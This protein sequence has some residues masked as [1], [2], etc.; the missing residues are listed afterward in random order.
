MAGPGRECKFEQYRAPSKDWEPS[1]SITLF[2]T[3]DSACIKP[4][5]V[6]LP[7]ASYPSGSG[8]QMTAIL[9][10]HGLHLDADFHSLFNKEATRLREAVDDAGKDLILIAPYLGNDN[11]YDEGE[12]AQAGGSERYLNQVLKGLAAWWKQT[13]G[14]GDDDD[15]DGTNF[16]IETLIIGCHSRG[17]AAMRKI[18]EGL[19]RYRKKLVQCW[20]FDCTY[21]TG[22]TWSD[23]ARGM[24]DVDLYFYFGKGTQGSD[25]DPLGF[26]RLAYGSPKSPLLDGGGLQHV[27]LAPALPGVDRDSI[28]FQSTAQIQRKPNG[29]SPYEDT[30]KQADP[31]LDDHDA[32]FRIVI[33]GSKQSGLVTQGGLFEHYRVVSSLLGPRIRQSFNAHPGW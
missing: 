11:G 19:G 15:S 32:Y 1:G 27:Y 5:S 17:G 9:W 7:N 10:L 12:L 4:T 13:H 25:A 23:W 8:S 26:W 14:R 33:H 6:Y 18:T 31:F 22:Q 28:A 30:R 3:R 16:K 21:G 29:S 24:G 20:G 2:S